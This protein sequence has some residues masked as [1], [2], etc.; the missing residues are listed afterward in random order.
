PSW[1][2]GDLSYGIYTASREAGVNMEKHVFRLEVGKYIGVAY[3]P[4]A[5]ANFVPDLVMIFCNPYDARRLALAA[6]WTN[7]EPI[8]TSIAA[9]NLCSEAVAQPFLTGKPVLAIPCGGD[10]RHGATQDD[11]IVFTTQVD[12]LEGMIVGLAEF[13]KSHCIEKLGEDTKLQKR[14]KE[15]AKTLDVKLGR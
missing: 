3:A 14:Y 9:R 10:R 4:I 1:L 6:A 13:E 8:K 7:G 11:E 12:R 5:K 2:E 15:M